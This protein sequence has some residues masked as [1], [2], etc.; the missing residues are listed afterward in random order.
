[1]NR[2]SQRPDIN[3]RIKEFRK[4][5]RE[6]IKQLFINLVE[7]LEP[8]LKPL[9][10][11]NQAS[12]TLR[13]ML[14]VAAVFLWG[15]Y[16][17]VVA[18]PDFNTIDV[19][20]PPF[21]GDAVD[22]MQYQ[23][24][25]L[26]AQL[27]LAAKPFFHPEVF[28]FVLVISMTFWL[29]SRAAA[30]YLADI[31]ELTNLKTAIR[32]IRQA[33]FLADRRQLGKLVIS[34]G[35]IPSR[36]ENSPVY[37]IGGPGVVTASLENLAVFEKVDGEPNIISP[38]KPA[39]I[40][41]FERLRKI[42]DLRDQFI[43]NDE[44]S[45]RTKDGIPV[46]ARGIR[47]S[48]S[49]KRD[50][51]RK[52]IR[53]EWGEEKLGQPLTF[54][55]E[56]ILKIVYEKPNLEFAD[57]GRNEVRTQIRKFISENTL[58]QFLVDSEDER[59]AQAVQPS[60]QT[61]PYNARSNDFKGREIINRALEDAINSSPETVI[62]LH[63]ISVGTWDT[64]PAIPKM[65]LE[66][67][68]KRLQGNLESTDKALTG[69]AI[70]TQMSEL[71]RLIQEVPLNT[72]GAATVQNPDPDEVFRKVAIAYRETLRSAYQIYIEENIPVPSHL[73]ISLKYLL[74]IL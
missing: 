49:V 64:P 13:S 50:K 31:F 35:R 70:G 38:D 43:D 7:V 61:V 60:A 27:F 55:E 10:A 3:R 45:G 44:V 68:Q 4:K 57:I 15:G 9:F 73:E 20:L 36:Y 51:S 19:G 59:S 74:K 24:R 14:F 28:R 56:S 48:F 21:G 69:V 46:T 53:D 16:A 6:V 30:I 26:F 71:Q 42:I 22:L 23:L 1:M 17:Y 41:G 62:E 2:P 11:I 39:V 8:I 54:V 40:E 52:V 33:A 25:L 65:H 12:A 66:A 72:F 67:W 37:Q 34:E 32:F 5:L 58:D 47:Y 18:P 63:W 29:T